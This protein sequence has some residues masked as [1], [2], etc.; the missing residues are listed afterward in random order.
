MQNL[1]CKTIGHKWKVS[2]DIPEGTHCSRCGHIDLS[3]M[4][5]T[6]SKGFHVLDMKNMP[7][8]EVFNFITPMLEEAG[9]TWILT[10]DNVAKI[11]KE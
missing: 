1:I 6:S 3:K 4:F 9:Y 11:Y 5:P 10:E 8:E 7:P 2:K